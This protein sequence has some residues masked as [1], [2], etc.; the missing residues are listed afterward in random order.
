MMGFEIGCARPL[1]LRAESVGAGSPEP[2]RLLYAS[3]LHLVP[4]RRR[5]VAQLDD[6]A[7]HLRPD[8]VLLGGDLVDR[9]GGIET[10]RECV[11][12][13]AAQAP[14]FAVL[15]NHDRWHGEAVRTA[16]TTAGGRWLDDTAVLRR[17]GQ[18]P[19]R[20]DG[21]PR[22]AAVGERTVLVAHHPSV[23]PKAVAC[24]YDVVLAGH[25]HGGQ[26]V[27]WQRGGRQYPGAWLSRWNGLR[28]RSGRT[29]MFVSRGAADTLP[30]RFR[31]PREVLSCLIH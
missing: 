1:L 16:V 7:A 31:C 21:R 2:W 3:D 10:L 12:A 9:H 20:L 15:G 22:P 17:H 23:F 24:G 29:A 5:L 25:L 11:D 30:I 13:L 26:C 28:F 19:L 14:V 18:P 4:S 8:A 6:I 27:L